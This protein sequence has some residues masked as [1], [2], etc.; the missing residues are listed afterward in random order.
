MSMPQT[1]KVECPHCGKKQKVTYYKSINV[2][3]EPKLKDRLFNGDINFLTCKNC[4][5]KTYLDVDLLYHDMEKEFC[6]QYYPPQFIQQ[7]ST[8]ELFE[9]SFPIK[10]K[11]LPEDY[12]GHLQHPH[13]VFNMNEMLYTILFYENL[14]EKKREINNKYE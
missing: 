5:K 2:S 11:K 4:E 9:K 12:K 6:V 10:C 7:K 1:E 14:L 8:Y 13:I 3:L